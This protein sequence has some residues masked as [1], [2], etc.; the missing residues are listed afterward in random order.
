MLFNIYTRD[1]PATSSKYFL[2][3]DDLAMVFQEKFFENIE[4][5]LEYSINII[6]DYYTSWRLK[7]NAEKTTA[8]F[9]HLNNAE[10]NRTPKIH[11]DS[12]LLKC[13]EYPRYLGIKLDRALTYNKHLSEV[14]M[15]VRTRCN[16]IQKL[17]GTTWGA[18]ADV[19]RIST[20]SLVNS[21]A[22]YG[23]PIW[24]KS[25]YV[26]KVDVQSNIALRT[27][28]G[29]TR[30]TPNDWL[31]VLANIVPAELRRKQ[32]FK[33]IINNARNEKNSLLYQMIEEETSQRLTSRKTISVKLKELE[34][35][36]ITE[37]WKRIW[38]ASHVINKEFII[39]PNEI[40]P[41][42]QLDRKLWVKLNRIR[43]NVGNCGY[44]HK[45]WN[46]TSDD[47]CDCGGGIQ[48]INHIVGDCNLRKFNGSFEE[49][50]NI[51]SQKAIDY[52]VQLDYNL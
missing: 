43:T 44:W 21:V 23:A 41:G 38:S 3:A 14:A 39:N 32:A 37:E 52:L 13:E 47:N 49:L 46:L 45:K 7:L 9:F 26:N 22:D 40:L 35:F 42:F 11:L 1:L 6:K 28:S 27:I 25:K 17:C 4:Q 8:T 19:L 2:Y 12:V 5:T 36:E 31:P 34:N 33:N 50:F 48:T 18:N 15:K 51:D 30:N 10:A 20:I 16:I 24:F 29:V